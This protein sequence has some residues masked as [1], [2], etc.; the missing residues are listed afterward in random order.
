MAS[1]CSWSR[2]L[3]SHA[4]SALSSSWLKK[5]RDKTFKCHS[6]N[7]RWFIPELYRVHNELLTCL[8]PKIHSH[9]SRIISAI[10]TTW[11]QNAPRRIRLFH[12]RSGFFDDDVLFSEVL[13]ASHDLPRFGAKNALRSRNL[14]GFIELRKKWV[15]RMDVV[16]HIFG[17]VIIF[18]N[19]L[20]LSPKKMI[21]QSFMS[22]KEI[23][24]LLAP[25]RVESEITCKVLGTIKI[26]GFEDVKMSG[27]VWQAKD[28]TRE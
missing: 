1:Y 20:F 14:N 23:V 25:T 13:V 4:S 5:A 21:C 3:S 11:S 27:P 7:V 16:Y 6:V 28:N 18:H 8:P 19:R 9:L 26:A 10:S 17:K 22:I 12:D 24:S 15:W 2:F